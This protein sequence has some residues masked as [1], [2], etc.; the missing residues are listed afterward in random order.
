MNPIAVVTTVGSLDEARAM[1]RD[2]VERKLAACA[3][4]SAIESV[5]RWK[6]AVDTTHRAER[7]RSVAIT[8]AL[9]ARLNARS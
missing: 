9:S 4:I 6:G 5:C 2:L 3:Q 1:A 8:W 7:A